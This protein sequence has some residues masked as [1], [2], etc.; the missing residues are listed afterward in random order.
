MRDSL[1]CGLSQSRDSSFWTSARRAGHH[2][3]WQRQIGL[4]RTA[5]ATRPNSN[6]PSQCEDR[7]QGRLYVPDQ[8]NHS[9]RRSTLREP[10][11]DCRYRAERFRGG[12]APSL[13]SIIRPADRRGG[14]RHLR[15][16]IATTSHSHS[17]ARAVKSAQLPARE[18]K[19][20]W[21]DL[22]RPL[23]SMGPD[24]YRAHGGWLTCRERRDNH[25]PQKD[26]SDEMSAN[27]NVRELQGARRSN[28]KGIHIH[29]TEF[30]LTSTAGDQQVMSSRHA[31]ALC[32][33]HEAGLNN[34]HLAAG[35][36]MW[37]LH[38][39]LDGQPIRSCVTPVFGGS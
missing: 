8:N 19:A 20:S 10:S 34:P 11:D 27:G 31:V 33:S 30:I 22:G 18:R 16:R 26:S 1:H 5:R 24:R 29:D 7:L 3:G 23:S 37:R 36:T 14:W 15:C 2:A 12:K 13:A 9:I 39:H 32:H 35:L 38:V 25:R 17:S 21:T 6:Q 28:L 4:P